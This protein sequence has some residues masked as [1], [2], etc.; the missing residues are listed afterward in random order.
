MEYEEKRDITFRLNFLNTAK[1][2]IFTFENSRHFEFLYFDDSKLGARKSVGAR[3]NGRW[4][5]VQ[6]RGGET[7]RLPVKRT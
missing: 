2:Q 4:I 5:R 6:K 7:A 1:K 3:I